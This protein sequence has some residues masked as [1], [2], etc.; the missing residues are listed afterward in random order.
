MGERR[1]KSGKNVWVPLYR[2]TQR[3][4]E[5]P[6]LDRQGNRLREPTIQTLWRTI[7][8]VKIFTVPELA[9]LASTPD[10]TVSVPSAGRYVTHLARGRVI[11]PLPKAA[12]EPPRYRLVRDIGARAPIILKTLSLYDPN[13]N[14]VLGDSESIEAQP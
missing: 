11:A 3:P 8:M 10:H 12:G 1:A 6:R 13:A 7:K 2:L 9:E 5:T 4:A 14:V